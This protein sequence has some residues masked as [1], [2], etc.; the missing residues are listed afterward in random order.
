M[1]SSTKFGKCVL[2]VVTASL[3]GCASPAPRILPTASTLGSFKPDCNIAKE[4]L[5]WLR[6]IRPTVYEKRDA[7]L[8]VTLWGEFSKEFIANK[9]V[10]DNRIDYLI[11]VNIKEIYYRCNFRNSSY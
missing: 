11:D 4:Q 9:D 5:E 8:Q 10:S 3:I 6:S 1:L 2:V 7:Y